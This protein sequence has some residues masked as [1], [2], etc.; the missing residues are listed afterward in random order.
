MRGFPMR[1]HQIT[2]QIINITALQILDSSQQ[3]DSQ[4][5]K[6]IISS[7]KSPNE[8]IKPP[9]YKLN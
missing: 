8:R 2:T 6:P 5:K 7:T 4:M 9:N 3:I 1:D